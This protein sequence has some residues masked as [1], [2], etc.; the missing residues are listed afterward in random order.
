MK[1]N[2]PPELSNEPTIEPTDEF[3]ETSSLHVAPK[4]K[5]DSRAG[6]RLLVI[7]LLGSHAL[8]FVKVF[9]VGSDVNHLATR[10]Q[11]TMVQTLDGKTIQVQGMAS[12][13][14]TP[15]VVE[16]FINEWATLQYTWGNDAGTSVQLKDTSGKTALLKLPLSAILA[17]SLITENNGYRPSFLNQIVA[18]I[19][20]LQLDD[21]LFDGSRQTTIQINKILVTPRS[22]PGMWDVKLIAYLQLMEKG[23]GTIGATAWNLDVAVAAVPPPEHPVKDDLTPLQRAIYNMNLAGLRIQNIQK[24]PV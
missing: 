17:S 19:T 13:Y 18:M 4:A 23:G 15:Q 1:T 8:L 2:L 10:P 24:S 9:A 7:F 12:D 21:N 22:Q 11:N 20:E 3:A 16:R 5:F 6:L 14:R